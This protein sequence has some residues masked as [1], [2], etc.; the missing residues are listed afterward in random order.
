MS[1]SSCTWLRSRFWLGAS[2]NAL[3]PEFVLANCSTLLHGN[4][5]VQETSTN[6]FLLERR[7]YVR[8]RSQIA[9][10]KSHPTQVPFD[11]GKWGSS[12]LSCSVCSGVREK[13]RV[14]Q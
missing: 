8:R 11:L 14:R 12:K 9:S 1:C 6:G 13:R 7:P 5:I 10:A 3:L 4:R 2:T